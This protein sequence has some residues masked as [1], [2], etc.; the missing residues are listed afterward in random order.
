L[1]GHLERFHCEISKKVTEKDK[2]AAIT[3]HASAAAASTS[4]VCRVQGEESKLA[5]FFSTD[6]IPVTMTAENF[7]CLLISFTRY[8]L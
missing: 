4:S 1:K 6:K 5:K 8:L 3:Q 7:A 2:A